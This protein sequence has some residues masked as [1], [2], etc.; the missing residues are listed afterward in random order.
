AIVI[1]SDTTLGG[2]EKW[3]NIYTSNCRIEGKI[4]NNDSVMAYAPTEKQFADVYTIEKIETKAGW[5]P[6]QASEDW[7]TGYPFELEDF[8]TAVV[9]KRQPESDLDLAIWTT[10]A[11]YAAYLSAQEGKRVAIPRGYTI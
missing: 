7:M 5:S 1:A 11:M 8:I 4:S 10:K 6:A 9:E 3:S 2:I